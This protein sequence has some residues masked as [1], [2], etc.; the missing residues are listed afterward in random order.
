MKMSLKEYLSDN[1][2]LIVGG[3]FLLIGILLTLI[4]LVRIFQSL[5]AKSW[6][7]THGKITYSKIR[8]SHSY[9][10]T[11]SNAGSRHRRSTSY[12]PEVE[13]E[14]KIQDTD[15]K[16]YR[17]FYGSKVGASWKWRRSKK[18]IDKYPVGQAV[19][20]FYNPSNHKKALLEPGIHREL[21]L[22]FILGTLILYLGYVILSSLNLPL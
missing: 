6:A 7:T 11:G 15:F 9:S 12:R 21:V 2:G 10:S 4:N 5:L 16:S 20:V 18:Y 14:Y 19:K 3:V 22:G 8:T 13:F 1:P 17:I